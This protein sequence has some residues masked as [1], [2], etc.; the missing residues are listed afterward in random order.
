[1]NFI[2]IGHIWIWFHMVEWSDGKNSNTTNLS[3]NAT[4]IIF[5]HLQEYMRSNYQRTTL[6]NHHNDK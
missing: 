3:E 2:N 5:P 4:N 6:I 1:M